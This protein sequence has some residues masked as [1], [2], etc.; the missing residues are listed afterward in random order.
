M[1]PL[2]NTLNISLIGSSLSG[3]E[4]LNRCNH[5]QASVGAACHA[6]DGENVSASLL[7][8]GISH[9]VAKRA[10]RL[11]LGRDTSQKDIDVIVA[12]LKS[13]FV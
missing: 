6:E 4:I 9:E 1:C 13:V 12:D 5:L 7:A 8:H 2:S 11:S 3:R 10:I